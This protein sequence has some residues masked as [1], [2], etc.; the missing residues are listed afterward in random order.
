MGS[1][2]IISAHN[3]PRL[4]KYGGT[5]FLE[6]TLVVEGA[7]EPN[8]TAQKLY[9]IHT[10]AKGWEWQYRSALAFRECQNHDSAWITLTYAIEP[11]TWEEARRDIHRWLKRAK[12]F[13]YRVLH[14]AHNA[15]EKYVPPTYLIVEEEG[16]LNGRKHFHALWH[17]HQPMPIKSWDEPL[18]AWEHGFT[19]IKRVQ[20]TPG[21]QQGLAVYIAKYCSKANGKTLCSS[22]YGLTR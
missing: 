15:G 19:K 22:H 13:H 10:T 6:K 17:S 1:T 2:Q 5:T 3:I 20:S 12:A 4:T 14:P 21:K 8:P 9:S 18:I 11:P 7:P 16:Q